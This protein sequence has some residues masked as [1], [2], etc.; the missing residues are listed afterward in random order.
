MDFPVSKKFRLISVSFKE[1]ALDSPSFRASVNHADTQMNNIVQWSSALFS[2]VEKLLEKVQ[3]VKIFSNA[4]LEHLVPGFLP[5]GLLDQEYTVPLMTETLKHLKKLWRTNIAY[6]TV[7]TA[8]AVDFNQGISSLASKYFVVKHQFSLAQ[9]KYDQYL[10]IYMS[11]VKNKDPSICKEDAM[12]LFQVR[13]AYLRACLNLVVLLNEIGLKLDKYVISLGTGLWTQKESIVPGGGLTNDFPEQTFRVH[14]S[15]AWAD[16]YYTAMERLYDD[17]QLARDQVEISSIQLFSPSPDVN[18]YD[19]SIINNHMLEE[20][21]E[22]ANEKHGYLFMK[23]YVRGSNTNK[24]IWVKRWVFIKGG[25]LGMLVL[26][27]SRTFV[28]ETDKIGL[29]LCNVKYAPFEDRMFC[30]E[31]KTA[32]LSLIFQAESLIELKSWLKVFEN[33]KNRIKNHS[34]DS[35]TLR[36]ASSKFPPIVTE[37]N[38]TVDTV[39]DRQLSNTKVIN[40]EGQIITSSTLSTGIKMHEKYFKKH[41]YYQIPSIKPPLMTGNTKTAAI[42]YAFAPTT[43]L[44]TALTANIW[45]TVNWGLYYLQESPYR[46]KQHPALPMSAEQMYSEALKADGA[47]NENEV[48]PASNSLYPEEYHPDMVATDIEMRAL[49]ESAIDPKEICLLSFGCLWSPNANQELNSRIFITNKSLLIYNQAMGFMSLYKGSFQSVASI[50]FTPGNDYD[51]LKIFLV[52]EILK[53]R[54]FLDDWQLLEKKMDYLIENKTREQSDDTREM[55]KKLNAITKDHIKEK[56]QPQDNNNNNNNNNN[57]NKTNQKLKHSELIPLVLTTTTPLNQT[58]ITDYHEGALLETHNEY[59]LPAK[60][61]F[62]AMFGD[63]SPFITNVDVIKTTSFVKQPWVSVDGKLCKKYTNTF[64]D[65][66]A[67]GS[68]FTVEIVIHDMVEDEYYNATY[69][70]KWFSCHGTVFELKSRFVI[71][72]QSKASCK[73]F[74]YGH[75]EFKTTSIFKGLSLAVASGLFQKER[76][77]YHYQLTKI[78]KTIGSHGPVAKAF[79]LYGGLTKDLEPNPQWNSDLVHVCH[80]GFRVLGYMFIVKPMALVIPLL[81][82]FILVIVWLCRSIFEQIT[83]NK[84]LVVVIIVLSMLNSFLVGKAGVSYWT[85]HE[86]SNLADQMLST[87]Y[88]ML[89]RAVYLKDLQELVV[90]NDSMSMSMSESMSSM[91]ESPE[92]SP[93][94][95]SFNQQSFVKNFELP[96]NWES[97][98]SDNL[99]RTVAENLRQSYQDIG[100]KRHDLLVQFRILNQMEHEIVDAEWRNWLMSEVRRCDMTARLNMTELDTKELQALHHYCQSCIDEYAKVAL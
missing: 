32:D 60:A 5:E 89:Q 18:D 14:R 98:Y 74:T 95:L 76:G 12:Q 66:G 29:L 8:A 71:I 40:S 2:T 38:S 1:A 51:Q 57:S 92:M 77:N 36:I 85:V 21:D 10:L 87:D 68:P 91:S 83:V 96:S 31:V 24:P 67:Y 49:F 41:L 50:Q 37:F 33:D 30:F 48:I 17:I 47:V 75:C 99:T 80:L 97:I 86:A 6:L 43:A 22:S 78:A 79:Y 53:V 35:E 88:M 28:Q 58:F 73:V 7:G 70:R 61:I 15:R 69:T 55:V 65:Q 54:V 59:Q 13:K 93:V 100:V 94:V 16:A 84:V 4:V 27:P 46:E 9:E 39:V 62:H 26:S 34:G 25:V 52:D 3:D 23:T 72:A 42:S 20:I 63:H 11:S 19:S 82:K 44:P 45:G 56:K 81:A 90:G 64:I